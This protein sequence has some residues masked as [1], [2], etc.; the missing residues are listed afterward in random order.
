MGKMSH[1]MG[2]SMVFVPRRK[3]A[4]TLGAMRAAYYAN[5]TPLIPK[6]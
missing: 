2:M 3:K 6:A 5:I 4:R 1:H